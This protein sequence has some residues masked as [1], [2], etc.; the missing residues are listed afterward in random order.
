MGDHDALFKRIF[1]VPAHAAAELRSVLPPELVAV[2]DFSRLELVSPSF[3]RVTLDERHADLLFRAPLLQRGEGDEEA[4]VYN[5]LHLE[6]YTLMEHRS[7]PDPR[8]PLR[9][10][11]YTLEFWERLLQSEPDRR[12]LPPVISLVVHHG[13]GGWS[14]PRSVHEMVEGLDQ[15]PVLRA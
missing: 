12:T 6:L 2:V 14:A 13:P 11:G 4:H 15:Y 8:M 7:G 9:V 1:S 10:M 3:V 5:H